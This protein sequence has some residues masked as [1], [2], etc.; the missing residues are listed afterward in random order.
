MF[1]TL[2]CSIDAE[3]AKPNAGLLQDD[4]DLVADYKHFFTHCFCSP[5]L[6][7]QQTLSAAKRVYIRE[8][9]QT[10]PSLREVRGLSVADHFEHEELGRHET[11]REIHVRV[12]EVM[13]IFREMKKTESEDKPY[14]ILLVSHPNFI[15]YLTGQNGKMG[16][17]LAPGETMLWLEL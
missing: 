11:Y 1:I 2:L 15:Y 5:L 14:L 16:H 6:R 9:I 12:A 17:L 8:P 7:A 3:E 13:N 4:A 10:L